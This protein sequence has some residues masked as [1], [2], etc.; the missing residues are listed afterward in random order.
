MWEDN[1]KMDLKG[2]EQKGT[3]WNHVALDGDQWQA[4]MNMVMNTEVS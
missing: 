4:I 1:I 2:T 3:A